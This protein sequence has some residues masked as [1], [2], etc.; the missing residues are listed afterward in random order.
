MQSFTTTHSQTNT[1]CFS[2]SYYPVGLQT[3]LGGPQPAVLQHLGIV[4]P[5]GLRQLQWLVKL[6]VADQS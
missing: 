4:V 5:K 2:K 1:Q 3:F 6:W